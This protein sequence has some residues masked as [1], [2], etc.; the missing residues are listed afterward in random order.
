M[1]ATRTLVGSGGSRHE[2][3]LYDGPARF[4]DAVAPF[5]LE[6]LQ[7]GE[8]VLVAV[9]RAKI[10]ALSSRVGDAS[11]LAFLDIEQVGA[12]PARLT[13]L[14]RDFA[15]SQSAAGRRFRGV[16]EPVWPGRSD[17]EL[18]ECARHEELLNLV[19]TEGPVWR[20]AC[21]YDVASLPEAVVEEAQRTH[22]WILEDE[23]GRASPAY[24]GLEAI[25]RPFDAPLAAA[26]DDAVEMA[27]S[28]EDLAEV[29][30]LVERLADACGLR[31]PRCGDLVLAVDEAA[32]N[33]VRHGAG[34]G[35]FLG[36]EQ[37]GTI[38]CEI[39]DRGSF[40]DV[41]AGRRTP[42]SGA[43]SGYG[44][45]LA[46]QLCDLVQIRSLAGGSVVRLHMRIGV[47][48]TEPWVHHPVSR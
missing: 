31:G 13:P 32:A 19:L 16:G 28:R 12:N 24:R 35:S 47:S 1:T 27:F 11:G 15:L 21:P 7:D 2:A 29:R 45:W 30:R 23:E 44:L 8:V 25:S 33:S 6:G 41:M 14:W 39:A 17:D 43:T 22:P 20:L 18:V 36:W 38:V 40:G 26:P 5:V 9:A 37:D 3:L 48:R 10:E 46:N 4:V 42:A 34:R